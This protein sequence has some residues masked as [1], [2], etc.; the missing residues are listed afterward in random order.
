MAYRERRGGSGIVGVDYTAGGITY[1]VQA[2]PTLTLPAWTQGTGVVQQVGL[3]TPNGD[4]TETVAVRLLSPV[5][6]ANPR[7]FLRLRLTE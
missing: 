5:G 1:T 7:Y 4:G 6:P 2:A 3:G